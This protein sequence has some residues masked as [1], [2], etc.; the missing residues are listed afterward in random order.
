M[1]C[2]QIKTMPA[3]WLNNTVFFGSKDHYV[4][5][6]HYSKMTEP[7]IT[8]DDTPPGNDDTPPGNDDTPPG[9]DDTPPGDDDTLPSSNSVDSDVA[10]S[11][12]SISGIAIGSC[13]F[14]VL[15]FGVCYCLV[16]TNFMTRCGCKKKEDEKKQSYW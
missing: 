8:D 14:C 13:L 16:K 12:A 9:N 15:F 2:V 10:L 5:A 3:F 6:V 4:Y 11:A 1:T 7:I